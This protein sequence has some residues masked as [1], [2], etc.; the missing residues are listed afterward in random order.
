MSYHLINTGK[1]CAK[2]TSRLK[3]C[4]EKYAKAHKPVHLGVAGF[5]FTLEM[6]ALILHVE[7]IYHVGISTTITAWEMAVITLAE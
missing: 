5:F 6:M 4:F 3:L 2:R 7:M 1:H